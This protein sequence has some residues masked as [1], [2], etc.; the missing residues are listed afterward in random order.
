LTSVTAWVAAVSPEAQIGGGALLVILFLSIGVSLIGPHVRRRERSP[1]AAEASTAEQPGAP[2]IA[3]FSS[4][5]AKPELLEEAPATPVAVPESEVQLT[6]AADQPADAVETEAIAG[7]EPEAEVSPFARPEPEPEVAAATQPSTAP[8]TAVVHEEAPGQEPEAEV[9][10]AAE[11]TP[12]PEPEPV[13]AFS[14]PEA[15]PEP[16]AALP[17]PEAQPEPVAALPEPET[18]VEAPVPR[19]ERAAVKEAAPTIERAPAMAAAPAPIRPAALR[20]SQQAAATARAPAV[21][22]GV[23]LLAGV[24]IGTLLARLIFASPR[25]KK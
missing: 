22:M 3:S 13:A 23:V 5:G 2:A 10:P 17:E 25:G 16:V 9:E 11:T 14:Q 7:V 19:E 20:R 1:E 18:P 4:N 6:A 8:E 24:A 21:P 12:E 15:Q